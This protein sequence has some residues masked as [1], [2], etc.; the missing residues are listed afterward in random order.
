MADEQSGL[1]MS[2]SGVW[3]PVTSAAVPLP[4]GTINQSLRHDGDGWIANNTLLIDETLGV[5][6]PATGYY[7][8]NLPFGTTGYGFRDN[9]GN[10]QYKNLGGAWTNIQNP[11]G[12]IDHGNLTGLTDQA[13]HT[14]VLVVD[15]SRPLTADW[16]IG[17]G[18]T[19]EAE[20]IIARDADGLVLREDSDTYG[21]QI[22]D[23]GDVFITL[24]DNSGARRINVADSDGFIQS[25]ISSDG[26]IAAA[27]SGHYNFGTTLGDT[28]YGF[29]DTGSKVQF[30]HPAGTWTDVGT[31]GGGT[32]PVGTENQTVR[33]DV[34]NTMVATSILKTHTDGSE[35][36]VDHSTGLLPRLDNTIYK[37]EDDE[38]P[39]AS[40]YTIGTRL[41]EYPEYRNSTTVT[42][43]DV[44]A[45]QLNGFD[46]V[47]DTVVFNGAIHALVDSDIL[48]WNGVNQWELVIAGGGPGYYL[49]SFNGKLYTDDSGDLLEWDGINPQVKVADSIGYDDINAFLV[50]NGKLYAGSDGGELWEWDGV[51]EWVVVAPP[52]VENDYIESL[53]VF[54]NK[55]YAGTDEGKL[56]EWNGSNA[57]VEVAPQL[58]TEDIG[59]I[60]VCNDKLYGTTNGLYLFEW[61]GI[62]AWVSVASPIEEQ[63]GS[64]EGSVV[65]NDEIFTITYDSYLFKWNGSSVWEVAYGA[66]PTTINYLSLLSASGTLFAGNADNGELYRAVCTSGL[67]TGNNRNI[68]INIGDAWESTVSIPSGN[69]SETLRFNADRELVRSTNLMNDGS[70]R[71]Y[72]PKAM[73]GGSKTVSCN[74]TVNIDLGDCNAVIGTVTDD[75]VINVTGGNA[76]QV[77]TF[78]LTEDVLGGYEVTFNTGFATVSSVT[79]APNASIVIAYVCDGNDWYELT[80]AS[81]SSSSII[82]GVQWGLPF[83]WVFKMVDIQDF[84][85]P[86]TLLT[87]SGYISR[88]GAIFVPISGIP[89]V[90]ETGYG[91]YNV[92]V[93]AN[94]TKADVITMLATASGAANTDEVFFPYQYI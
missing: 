3:V 48:R 85:T 75:T 59:S 20:S 7:N 6:V 32:L 50:Y 40:G 56:L 45:P 83:T 16:D 37:S 11:S 86:K 13:D 60:T 77:V 35:V 61:N 33:Y 43:W 42:A 93:P 80:S 24:G 18:R 36:T 1:Y 66:Y 51:D 87:P 44:V 5:A 23:D 10:I 31:G 68:Y 65:L 79:A 63:Y 62:N 22:E 64:G 67:V 2:L 9:I 78:I 94:D 92:R 53:A 17:N 72:T 54:N 52:T 46:T 27:G 30:K 49:V 21:I 69:V 34:S 81:T 47:Y 89:V 41:Y 38:F 73:H 19:I 91:W 25:I 15:G 71:V 58:L 39:V 90:A 88:D 57:W 28:G 76:S 84:A 55:I 26:D 29:R 74:G 4:S 14:W 12:V 8:F 82:G 70:T